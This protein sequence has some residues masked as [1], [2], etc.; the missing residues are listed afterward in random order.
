[1][2]LPVPAPFVTVIHGE[3]SCGTAVVHEHPAGAVTLTV[4]P[5][6]IAGIVAAVGVIAYVHAGGAFVPD[7]VTLKA[8]PAIVSVPDRELVLV[9]A[10][11]E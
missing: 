8:R 6:P 10:S 3:A 5:P 7:C 9:L 4:P 2:P 11:T 1:M